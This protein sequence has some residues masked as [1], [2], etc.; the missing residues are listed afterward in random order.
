[1]TPTAISAAGVFFFI[2]GRAGK[3]AAEA[4]EKGLIFVPLL[5]GFSGWDY[6]KAFADSLFCFRRPPQGAAIC[7]NLK[8][9]EKV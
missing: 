7:H 9:G 2:S 6:I 1:M 3:T 8:F 4:A 5:Y